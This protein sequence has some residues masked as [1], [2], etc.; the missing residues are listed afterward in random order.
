MGGSGDAGLGEINGGVI[1][2]RVKR[3]I[4]SGELE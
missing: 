2:N 1:E 3:D 4:S